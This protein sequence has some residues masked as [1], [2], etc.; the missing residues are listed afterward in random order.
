MLLLDMTA[1]GYKLDKLK[2]K[3]RYGTVSAVS[4]K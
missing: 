1:V 2:F 4:E 3:V